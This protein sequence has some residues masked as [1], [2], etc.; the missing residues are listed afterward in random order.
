M[1]YL[2]KRSWR[3]APLLAA[4]KAESSDS[5]QGQ[6]LQKV[7]GRGRGDRPERVLRLKG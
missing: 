7:K 4:L 2:T 6:A 3:L 5:S 1:P